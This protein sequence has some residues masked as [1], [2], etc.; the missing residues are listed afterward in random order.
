MYQVTI[1]KMKNQVAITN[2]KI[3]PAKT[4]AKRPDENSHKPIIWTSLVEEGK[5]NFSQALLLKCGLANFVAP[6][7]ASNWQ[8]MKNRIEYNLLFLS[9]VN[10]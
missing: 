2:G 8:A 1:E 9:S 10:H 7:I 6:P 5:R 4:I 3:F